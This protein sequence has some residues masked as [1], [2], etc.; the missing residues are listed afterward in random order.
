MKK[1]IGVVLALV[2]SSLSMYGVASPASLGGGFADAYTAF[3]PLY[4]FY[5]SYADYLFYGSEVVIPPGVGGVCQSFSATLASL[6]VEMII[7]T[8][9]AEAVTYI[10]HLRQS[11]NSFCSTYASTIETVAAMS[12]P[13]PA[14][15]KE[16]A[17]EG[18]FA[19]VSDMNKL[20][21]RAFNS[22]LDGLPPGDPQWAFAA[23]FVCRTLMEQPRITHIES[24][25][26]RILLGSEETPPPPPDL[27]DEIVQSLKEL[28]GY[29]GKE[30]A[31]VEAERI[32]SLARTIYEFLLERG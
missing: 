12:S 31:T 20:L 22:A 3:A 8:E 1:M 14:F 2:F 25:L 13:D 19:S 24:S 28:S 23:A 30:I 32:K 7:Q 27:P 29:A 4:A 11:L 18:F 17:D 21:E 10:V 6:Q 5:R 15:L 26:E 16:A 9:S